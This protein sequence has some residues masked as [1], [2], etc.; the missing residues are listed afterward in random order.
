M[1]KNNTLDYNKCFELHLRA[2]KKIFT[3]VAKMSKNFR[4]LRLYRIGTA[5]SAKLIVA[6]CSLKWPEK[7]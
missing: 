2:I 7:K 3:A 1:N 6:I 4:K 5:V